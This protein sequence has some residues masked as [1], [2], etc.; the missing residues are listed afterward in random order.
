[1]S[2]ITAAGSHGSR[3]PITSTGDRSQASVWAVSAA[4]HIVHAGGRVLRL[5]IED[6]M[7]MHDLILKDAGVCVEFV[8]EGC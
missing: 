2:S 4:R 6:T 8:Q 5:N 1:M 3:H 7:K